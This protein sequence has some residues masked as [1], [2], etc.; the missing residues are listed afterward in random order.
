VRLVFGPITTIAATDGEVS[1]VRQIPDAIVEVDGSALFPP[2]KLTAILRETTAEE[3]S[4]DVEDGK[5]KIKTGSSRFTIPLEVA[6]E[7]PESPKFAATDFIT[8]GASDVERIVNRSIFYD[9]KGSRFVLQG[10]FFD[11]GTELNC[12][13]TDSKAAVCVCSPIKK[14]GE[15]A[16]A[17]AVSAKTM[18]LLQILSTDGDVDVSL[19]NNKVMFRT[20]MGIVSSQLLQG[21][22]P[23][24]R[25]FW[26]TKQGRPTISIVSNILASAIR[27]SCITTA[28][29][30]KAIKFKFSK[31]L[32]SMSS[33]G[34]GESSVE[35]PIGFEGGDISINLNP[36][37]ILKALKLVESG[38]LVNLMP[39]DSDD[40]LMESDD[41]LN[42]V[43]MS[44]Q[45]E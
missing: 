38:V 10:V 22:Y 32:L 42:Y 12:V 24:W 11:I 21:R 7:F 1:I 27:Q 14:T 35:L 5:A 28:A 2:E 36:D 26:P 19:T 41:G 43:Q 15:I 31:G 39:V 45:K 40:M 29:E 16:I 33:S 3:I 34:D 9:D 6:A 23:D 17:G 13:T 44:I 30:S 8:V 37:Y 4:I 18:R 25:K 20:P